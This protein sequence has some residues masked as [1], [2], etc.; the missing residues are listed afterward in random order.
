MTRV[1]VAA[2]L[3][4]LGV[5]IVM[6]L[7]GI[8][9]MKSPEPWLRYIPRFFRFIMPVK[10]TGFMRLHG[11]LNI[12]LG[13]LLAASIWQPAMT[14]ICAIWWLTITPFAFYYEFSVGLRD[15]A[16]IMSLVAVIVIG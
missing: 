2:L 8:S 6:A 7:F 13:V 16:I 3:I 14:W 4:R 11:F 5:G 9:Q 12:A 10:P 15:L 1:E